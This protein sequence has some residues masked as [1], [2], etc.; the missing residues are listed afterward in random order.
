MFAITFFLGAQSGPVVLM[1][2]SEDTLEAAL[3]NM[4]RFDSMVFG[5]NAGTMSKNASIADD[6]GQRLNLTQPPLGFLVQDMRLAREADIERG[7]F[8]AVT[9]AK[10][11]ERAKT[12]PTLSAHFRTMQQGPA[13]LN[14]MGGGMPRF[15]G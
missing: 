14:P 3:A 11:Q 9:Q 8:Q 12:D 15:N 2:K 7:V 6:F 10:A 4:A 13:V 1:F 5:P